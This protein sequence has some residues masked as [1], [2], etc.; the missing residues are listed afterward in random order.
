MESFNEENQKGAT[1]FKGKKQKQYLQLK[2]EGITEAP[3][4]IAVF[5]KKSKD[6]VLGQTSMKETG[7]Y[8]VVCAVQNMW[9]MARALNI[10]IGWVSLINPRKIKRILNAP[11]ENQLVAYLCIG[12]V[13]E[14]LEKPELEIIK[15]ESRKLMN[16][17]IIN[18]KYK[19][20]KH[21]NI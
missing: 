6:P 7:L 11:A 13:V 15:W 1:Y 14:F 12:H 8:S 16:N 17:V 9:L 21:E 18:N 10:G 20:Q 3:V 19:I 5:Y 2:L 4:N